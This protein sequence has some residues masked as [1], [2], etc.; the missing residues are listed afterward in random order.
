MSYSQPQFENLIYIISRQKVA[1]P[2][3]HL[4]VLL[5]T[6]YVAHC[7]PELGVHVCTQDEFARGCDVTILREIP[8]HLNLFV[9]Y[10]LDSALRERRPYHL[11]RWNCEIFTNWLTGASPESQ[12]VKGWAAAIMIVGI[13]IA[14]AA[15]S[16]S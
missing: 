1:G 11:T 2:G 10:R 3:V 13:I 16:P 5:P 6:G 9:V 12:Q 4:G 14:I 7:T 8:P 15:S